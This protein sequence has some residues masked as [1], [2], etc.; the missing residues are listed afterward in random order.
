MTTFFEHST[1]KRVQQHDLTENKREQSN[2]SN[3]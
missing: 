1:E 3:Y 2:S